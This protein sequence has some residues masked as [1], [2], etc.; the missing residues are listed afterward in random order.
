MCPQARRELHRMDRLRRHSQLP[1]LQLAEPRAA[2]G[3]R[4]SDTSHF[5]SEEDLK[6]LDSWLKYQGGVPRPAQ[7][8]KGIPRP[9]FAAFRFPRIDHL[10]YASA[11]NRSY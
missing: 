10:A 7:S 1:A 6:T 4:V 5:T 3:A 2:K 9:T 8:L 11:G